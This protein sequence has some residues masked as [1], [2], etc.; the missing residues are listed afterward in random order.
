MESTNLAYKILIAGFQHET[1][2][3]APSL[4]TYES[5]VRGEGHPPMARGD[6]VLAIRDVNLPIGGFIQA[7]ERQGHTLLPV[8]W[9]AA[10]PS[11]QV[12]EDAYERIVGEIVAAAGEGGFDAIYLDLHGAM[13]AQHV[14]D[15]EG[16]L[17][18]RIRAKVGPSVP[19]V[20]SLD[21]HANVTERMLASAD[22]LVAYRTYPH[23][24]MADTGARAER[25][26]V[27]LLDERKPLAR[28]ARRLPFLIPINGMC[29]MLEPAR[30]M[31]EALGTLEQGP[32]V[33]LSFAP[34]FPAADFPECGP[35]IWGYG[36][37]AS[38]VRDAVDSLYDTMLRNEAQ[39]AVPFL[40]PDAAVAEAIRL[41]ATAQK[42][43]VIADTQDNPGAGADSNTTGMLRALLDNGAQDAALG[44]VWD[45]EAAAQAHAAGVGATLELALGG[46]S[47]T[48]GD[49]PFI[50]TFEVVALSDGRCRYDGPMMH[51]MQVEL[52][53]VA[54][55]KI[56]GVRIAVSSTK[57]QMLDRNLY[58][59]A[60]IVPEQMKILVNKSSVHFRADFQ[61]IAHTV[62]VA[63]APGPM[64]ADPADLPWKWLA[65]GIRIRPMGKSF[66]G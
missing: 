57:A 54:C 14:D 1:N 44:L 16:E 4:A 17:L 29:T 49:A 8:I 31:Y 52:G 33:S 6:A 48:P 60:G 36:E 42:P 30:S 51:G 46:R 50:G 11:A 65:R 41:S 19:V 9:T 66:G 62:L 20:A 24:D 58:R 55:L 13:V 64:T 34:G 38:A 53:P 12:T 63:K 35:V 22:A 61:P 25:L 37:E 7:S 59:V 47:G 43:V 39:W 45:P 27:R 2:T 21:L 32:V 3:F 10:S 28:A 18:A 23:V 15:G 26:L 5:F 40:S 56:G